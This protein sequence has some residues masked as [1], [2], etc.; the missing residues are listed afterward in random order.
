MQKR[1]WMDQEH[2]INVTSAVAD[3]EV[4]KKA[5]IP[6]SICMWISV[7]LLYGCYTATNKIT[8]ISIKEYLS[9]LVN[10]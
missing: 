3:Q 6:V 8:R 5:P 10:V 4:E 1:N 2:D 7:M 9:I